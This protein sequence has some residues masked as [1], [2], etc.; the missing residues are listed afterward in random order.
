MNNLDY[1]VFEHHE[2]ANTSGSSKNESSQSSPSNADIMNFLKSMNIKITQMDQKLGKL[3]ILEEKVNN[4]ESELVKVWNFVQDSNISNSQTMN[5]IT[6]KVD[7]FE[8]V[9]AQTNSQLS[10]LQNE[11]KLVYKTL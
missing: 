1:S 2:Q 9:L 6:D 4:M 5:K 10:E 11:K 8:L 7:N 3:D